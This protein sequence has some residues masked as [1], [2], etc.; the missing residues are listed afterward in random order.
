MQ[1]QTSIAIIATV[2]DEDRCVMGEGDKGRN[3]NI[4]NYSLPYFNW[5][6]VQEKSGCVVGNEHLHWQT[7]KNKHISKSGEN[8]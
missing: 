3:W 1:H 7:K 2:L 4:A 8:I 5:T 6:S